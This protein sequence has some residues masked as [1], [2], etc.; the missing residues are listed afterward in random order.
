[1]SPSAMLPLGVPQVLIAGGRDTIVPPEHARAYAAAGGADPIRVVVVESAGHF[2]LVTPRG[3][4]WRELRHA[5][6]GM[7]AAAGR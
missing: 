4:A 5:L 3:K 1:A 7:P 6:R 2:E